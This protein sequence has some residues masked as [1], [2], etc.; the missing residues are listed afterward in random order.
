MTKGRIFFV[1]AVVALCHAYVAQAQVELRLEELFS[2]FNARTFHKLACELY[3]SNEPQSDEAEIAVIF[4][5]GV[6]NLDMKAGYVFPD[7]LNLCSQ[8]VEGDYTVTLN[9]AFEN[10]ADQ[11]ADLEVTKKA[12]RYLIEKLDN[13]EAREEKLT[14]LLK[15]TEEKNPVLT[16]EL[17]TQLGLLSAEKGDAA[18]AITLLSKAYNL[19]PYNKLAFTK[20][21]ELYEKTGQKL[22]PVAYTRNLRLTVGA[23]PLDINAVFAFAENLEKN[24]LYSMAASAYEYSA[25][26]FGYLY[27]N[28]PLPASIYLPWAIASYNTARGQARC[29]ELARLIRQSD[30][31]DLVLEAMAGCAARKTGDSEQSEQILDD[32]GRKAEK[33]LGADSVAKNVTAEQLGWFYCFARVDNEKALVWANRAYSADSDSVAAKSI[34]AYALAM[35]EKMELAGEMVGGLYQVSQIAAL[36]RGLIQLTAEDKENAIESLKAAVE[37]D[38]GSLAAEKAGKLLA[39]NSSEYVSG[40]YPELI[41]ATLRNEFSDRV[42][43]KF[44]P[45]EKIISAKLGL[46]GSEF[47][48]RAEFGARLVVTNNSSEPVVISNNGIFKGGIRVDAEVRGDIKADIPNLVSKKVRPSSA[49]EPAYYAAIPKTVAD[50]SAGVGRDRIYRL[51]RPGNAS[52]WD[53]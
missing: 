19:N 10:Y 35:N 53:C 7:I 44:K 5:D 48:Y 37:M 52:G 3:T 29:L 15:K 24:G 16:S 40:A 14:S 25:E 50:T 27:P 49:I 28:R 13:R 18:G 43:P 1:L 22:R 12:V 9:W 11:R 47:F 41:L 6:I 33:L 4:L 23:N 39:Q 45:V 32:A 26:L 34:L 30:R 38:P 31:F 17:N 42:V 51:S 8:F 20:L 2:P 46:D 36:T 21:A